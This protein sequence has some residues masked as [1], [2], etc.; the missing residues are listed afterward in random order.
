MVR[1][2]LTL[3]PCLCV[4]GGIG[5][6]VTVERIVASEPTL[7]EPENEPVNEPEPESEPAGSE[8]DGSEN[9]SAEESQARVGN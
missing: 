6:S 8:E 9:L 2:M 4:L 5:L 3:T 1:L 7:P